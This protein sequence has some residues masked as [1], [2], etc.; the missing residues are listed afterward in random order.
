[1]VEPSAWACWNGILLESFTKITKQEKQ[2]QQLF[3]LLVVTE[4]GITQKT[5]F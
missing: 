5:H 3:F 2:Q 1:V 4:N